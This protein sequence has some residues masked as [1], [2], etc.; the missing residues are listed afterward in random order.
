VSASQLTISL[1]TAD[2]ATVGSYPVVV[3]NQTPGGGP[4]LA[5]SFTVSATNPVPTVA[6]LSPSSLTAGATAQTLTI[7]GT[8]FMSSPTVTYNGAAHAAAYVSGSQLTISLT[9]ADLA[10]AGAYPVVVTNPAPGGGSSA[11]VNFT[12]SA[13]NP[14]PTITSLSPTSLAAGATAQ[15]LTINGTGFL[16]SSTVTFNSVAHTRHS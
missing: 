12:V 9:T 8:G 3:T 4:S 10:T 13:S 15:T 7:N 6:S 11:A 14:R 16:T 1:T 5:F 2:L